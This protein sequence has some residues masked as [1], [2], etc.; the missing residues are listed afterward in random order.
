[1]VKVK[2]AHQLCW[3]NR[4]GILISELCGCFFCCITFS[5]EEITEWVDNSLTAV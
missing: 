2:K 5:K 3:I 1:M 4:D